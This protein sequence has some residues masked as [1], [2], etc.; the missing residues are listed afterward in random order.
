MT[1]VEPADGGPGGRRPPALA[2]PD[3]AHRV[4]RPP[5]LGNYGSPVG[6]VVK[7]VALALLNAVVLWGLTVMADAGEWAF[8]VCRDRRPA[9]DRLGVPV[10]R[11]RI[12]GKYLLPGTLFL[13]V[14]AVYP[15]LYTVFISTTNYGTG[16]N[17]SKQQAIDQIELQ[18]ISA[19]DEATRYTLQILA[20]GNP[21]GEL[22]FL[23]T[24]PDGERFLG[25]T[26]DCVPL[27]E[28]DIVADGR[29][30]TV[31]GYVPLNAGQAQDRV[32]EIRTFVVPGPEG[33]ID[34]DG[35]GAAFT[36]LQRYVY[37]ASTGTM[38]DTVDD[39]VLTADGG[40]FVDDDGDA[41]CPAGAATSG[42]Q[43]R[44]ALHRRRHCAATS[45]ACSCG[46]WCSPQR[47]CSSR[48]RS[49]CCWRWCSTTR[50]CA[51]ASST[52]ASSSSRTPCPAS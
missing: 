45:S 11:R 4:R 15:V 16:N 21:G 50:R 46:R 37:D 7:L 8:L 23:L 10:A 32:A 34:N 27:D 19:T 3:A 41:C 38:V 25:T 12:P 13:L 17:L 6:I 2:A 26:D 40:Y 1:G 47:R 49:A 5:L 28:S 35:F 24:D 22:A 48:S 14:F 39:V 18:S 51:A 9:G 33:E 36:K 42:S 30:E 43:L 31:D 52:A 44:A 20:Q 29:R